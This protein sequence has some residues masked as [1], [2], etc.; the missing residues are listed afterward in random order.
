[1]PAAFRSF[2]FVDSIRAR[3]RQT[4]TQKNNTK[5]KNYDGLEGDDPENQSETFASPVS[6]CH[7]WESLNKIELK[8]NRNMGQF[9][10][11]IR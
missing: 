9:V 1:M 3:P 8:N 4:G 2:L 10:D 7:S 5:N 6:L 11:E